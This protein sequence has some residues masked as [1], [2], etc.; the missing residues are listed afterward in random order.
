MKA[1]VIGCG[2]QGR[3]GHVG[4]YARMDDV[5][6][7]AVC[8]VNRERA[9]TVAEEFN[10]PHVYSNYREM[11]D[12]HNFDLVSVCTPHALH[13]DQTVDAF[14]AGANVICEKALAVSSAEAEEMIAAC[15]R[16]GKKMSMGL[17]NRGRAEGRALKQ[18]ITEG[19]LGKIYYT[20]V[21]SGHVM[22]I[23]GYSVFHNKALS[24]GGV[25]YST[26]VHTLDLANFIIGD[27]TPVA[28]MGTMYQK[29]RQMKNPPISWKGTLEDF[30]TE[31]FAA[32]YIRFSDGS[33]L[34]LESNWLT[35]PWK[36]RPSIEILGDYGAAEIPLKIYLDE[37]A[38][39]FDRT[40]EVV[41]PQN[42]FFE[43]L[44]DFVEAVRDDRTPIVTFS[45]MLHVQQMMEGIYRS[46]ETGAGVRIDD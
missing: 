28:A 35:H 27:P 9:Q 34:S 11:L 41:E 15:K 36:Q 2:A 44:R 43:V 17:Q 13:K 30:E 12:N 22:S 29:V 10:V 32:G 5:E 1:A 45:E 14:D 23:P 25:L 4:N 40:P 3:G 21:V 16:N 8:D 26:A 39:V 19:G 31:D 24:G 46:A 42:P 20:R 37:G 7:L 18:F 33:G 6:L 38:E